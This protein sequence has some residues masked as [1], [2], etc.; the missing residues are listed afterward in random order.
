MDLYSSLTPFLLFSA[1]GEAPQKEGYNEMVN[2]IK[3][4]KHKR[5][6]YEPKAGRRS[7]SP[8]LF[9]FRVLLSNY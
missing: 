2:Y 5:E 9:W 4:E 8:L 1:L 6:T 3:T 7:E